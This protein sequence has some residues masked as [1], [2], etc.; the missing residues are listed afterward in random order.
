MTQGPRLY[1]EL[2]SWFHLLTPPSEYEEEAAIYR[3]LLGPVRTV[4]ELGSGGGN[5][6]S[7]LKAHSEM[8][9]VDP[10]EAMLDLSRALNPECRH[11]AG[12]MR[13]LRLDQRF[14]AVFIHD[15]IDYMTTLDDL[16]A[17]MATA[18]HHLEPGGVALLCPDHL[19]D[20][21]RPGTD[22]GGTDDGDRGLRYLEWTWDPDPSDTTY[23]AD[24]AY[25]LREGDQVR[26]EHDRHVCGLFSRAQW[27]D[28]LRGSG[29][30]PEIAP[31]PD[32]LEVFVA[33]V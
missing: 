6:A 26:V 21:F 4:L 18:R 9:L 8:T 2:A 24:Y 27:L 29:F 1:G 23:V 13:T 22:H 15:A 16:R 19:R 7:H 20:T 5:N 31:G 10:S 12:D 3:S 17:A 11:L 28:A 33:R 30:R 32:G 14:D 25:L